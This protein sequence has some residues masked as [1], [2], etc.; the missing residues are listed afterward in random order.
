[1]GTP[2]VCD[3]LKRSCSTSKQHSTGLCQS[4]VSDAECNLGQAC[5][6]DRYGTPAKDVGYFC[7]WK[8][9]DPMGGAP[10]NCFSGGRPYAGVQ[11]NATSIDGAI[12]NVC[13]LAVSSCVALNQFRSKDCAVASA[14]SDALCGVSPPSDAKCGSV[15]G[16]NFRCTVTCLSDAD[17][18]GTVCD[19]GVAPRVCRLQ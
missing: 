3:S 10:A 7:H 1:M 4:C 15:D 11:N 13:T 16:L 2:L 8:Q 6:L 19:L 18:P 12:S 14:P 9:G 5:V 17:C